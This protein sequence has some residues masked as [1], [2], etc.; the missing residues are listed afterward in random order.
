[1]QNTTICTNCGDVV[2][3]P[4]GMTSCF[5]GRCGTPVTMAAPAPSAHSPGY[6]PAA[7]IQN[8]AVCPGCGDVVEMP[9]GKTSC[10]CGRCGTPVAVSGN[11]AGNPYVQD[12][13][14]TGTPAKKKRTAL[15][16]AIPVAVVIVVLA[17]VLIASAVSGSPYQKAELKFFSGMFSSLSDYSSGSGGKLD[18]TVE[19]DPSK[20]FASEAD[21]TNMQLDGSVGYGNSQAAAQ[22][23]FSSDGDVISNIICLYDNTGLSAAFP[24]ISDYYLRWL[25]EN[26]SSGVDMSKLDSKKAGA[27]LKAIAKQYFKMAD[28]IA[29]VDKGVTL[30]VG[31][32]T[33]KCDQY[34]L[35]FN[36]QNMAEFLLAAIKELRRNSNLTDFLS[37]V[38]ESYGGGSGDFLDALDEIESQL[39]DLNSNTRLFRM[40]VWVSGNT[41]VARK[42]DKISGS[43]ATTISYQNLQKGANAH[44][45][46][47]F[48]TQDVNISFSGDFE[49]SG[50]GWSGT[51]KITVMDTYSK[52][53]MFSLKAT[54]TDIKRSGEQ[55]LGTIKFTGNVDDGYRT[56]YDY[57]ITLSLGKDGNRQTAALTGNLTINGY[58]T[59]T[60]DL[61]TLTLSYA[62]SKGGKLNIP[63]FDEDYA[64]DI[65]GNSSSGNGNNAEAMYNDIDDFYSNYDGGNNMVDSL[66]NA[67]DRVVYYLW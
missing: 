11:I 18:F 30:P 8:T 3:M 13:H 40:T 53:E 62:Y 12:F 44:I 65:N 67:L 34:T 33:L 26:G 1:M 27:T 45:E 51:P 24:D 19:Y 54:C 25:L 28:K 66:L 10:F 36:E 60:Y 43:S 20:Q 16:I 61:G 31:D 46:Y 35:D 32:A 47:N 14:V 6:N 50:G 63:K 59:D 5:C 48:S 37:G 39:N 22:L 9:T 57:S 42:I 23:S 49:K 4:E 38:I 56:T 17:I 55:V 15:F 21:I 7:G 64:V 29:T 2:E 41:A 58:S 52:Q